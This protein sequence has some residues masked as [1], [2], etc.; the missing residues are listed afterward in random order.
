LQRNI[1][2]FSSTSRWNVLFSLLLTSPFTWYYYQKRKRRPFPI[3]RRTYIGYG[4]AFGLANML[5]YGVLQQGR[6]DVFLDDEL[7]FLVDRNK[8][9]FKSPMTVYKLLDSEERKNSKGREPDKW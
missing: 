5:L 9:V 4:A 7:I 1:E 6:R 3:T 2:A 8:N